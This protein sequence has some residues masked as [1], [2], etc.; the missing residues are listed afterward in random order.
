MNHFTPT[1]VVDPLA[2][3]LDALLVDIAV[4]VQLP[5]GLHTKACGRY[6]AVRIYAER[7]GS[8]LR[9]L[10]QQFYPQGSMAI[11]GTTSTRGTDDE[12]DLDI[13]AALDL[14]PA[15]DPDRV[16]DLL[17]RSLDGYPTSRG[18][19]RQTR[20]VTVYYADR[21]HLDITPAARLPG[22]GERESHVF[23][24]N[25]DEPRSQHFHAAM[26]AYGFAEWYRSR[27][28]VEQ[29]FST[30]FN[31]RLVEAFGFE[32][33]ADAEVDD[34]PD[35]VPLV[36]KSVTTVALQLLKRFR[37]VSYANARARIPPSVMM[38][39][40]AGHA[41]QPGLSLSDMV[42]RQARMMATSIRQASARR[43][44]I[45]VV[46][47]IYPRD[48]FT[49]R[50]PESLAQQEDFASKLMDLADGL[51]RFK[52]VGASLEDLRDWL[53]DRFGS[54]VVSNSFQRF[55]RRTGRAVQAG[56]HA[57]TPRGGLYVPSA[58]ALVG[59]GAAMAAPAVPASS[60]TFRGGRY[61]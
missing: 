14:D 38:S 10:V 19:E 37:N 23:H 52:R 25:P 33:R 21:M 7:E 28:P 29:R 58:P 54:H 35:Q 48:C 32:V 26:N 45:M 51:A 44:K 47:P 60:H 43:E 61:W 46:N 1:R 9:G 31:D 4:S 57:Y 36:V 3:P 30:A 42:I 55:N 49:D 34:V 15:A 18:V 41:A 56:S 50:W 17:F 6:E 2:E 16:L 22:G 59:I 39:C 24:A 8:P 5:P 40:F 13:V 20:C 27:T 11:D 53:R 12:Y